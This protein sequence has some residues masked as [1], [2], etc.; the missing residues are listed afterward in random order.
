[1]V[2]GSPVINDVFTP[3]APDGWVVLTNLWWDAPDSSF[4]SLAAGYCAAIYT[5][6]SAQKAYYKTFTAT[7]ANQEVTAWTTSTEFA[8]S[9]EAA[10]SITAALAAY[11]TKT[12]ADTLLNAKAPLASPALTGSPTAPTPT[13]GDNDTSIATTAFVQA[14][15]PAAFTQSKAADGY[16]SLP[17]GVILQWKTVSFASASYASGAYH[18]QAFTWPLAFPTAHLASLAALKGDQANSAVVSGN[19]STPTTSGGS[20]VMVTSSTA[21]MGPSFT[22]FGIGH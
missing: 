19:I 17:G 3:G 13:A 22:V 20:V 11:Y 15:I 4:K 18:T 8:G 1:V 14:A 10:G 5:D 9:Y 12:A 7:A 21:T 2:V 16:V 6:S